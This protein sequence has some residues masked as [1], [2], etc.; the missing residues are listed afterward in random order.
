MLTVFL[1][2]VSGVY[3][4]DC[5]EG[6]VAKQGDPALL[7]HTNIPLEINKVAKQGEDMEAATRLWRQSD[8]IV[9]Q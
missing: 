5:H 8:Q 1:F 3:F 4:V 7:I 9:S 6:K 2:Q